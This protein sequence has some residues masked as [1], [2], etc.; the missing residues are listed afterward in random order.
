MLDVE[1]EDSFPRLRHRDNKLIAAV[2]D[3]MKKMDAVQ[4][5]A[6]IVAL[7][8][9][10]FHKKPFG[11]KNSFNPHAFNEGEMFL[12]GFLQ[13]LGY[14]GFRD[15]S[16]TFCRKCGN[17]SYVQSEDVTVLALPGTHER[18]LLPSV[19]TS[20]EPCCSKRKCAQ[21]QTLRAQKQQYRG[22]RVFL[23]ELTQEG[24]AVGSK[25][26][27]YVERARVFAEQARSLGYELRGALVH[28]V[29]RGIRR[30]FSRGFSLSS[31]L[32]T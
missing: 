2:L 27:D 4:Q 14:A 28:Q 11:M 21:L 19:S 23:A 8:E 13:C 3:G 31:P 5:Q 25:N 17:T 15:V 16:Q 9:S 18:A 26:A 20:Y 1:G 7:Q 6:A 10:W 22:G 24:D 12:T 29:R 30:A 32:S